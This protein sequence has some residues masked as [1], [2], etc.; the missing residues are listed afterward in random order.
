MTTMTIYPAL[1]VRAGRV[2]RLRQGDFGDETRYPSDP[3]SQARRYRAAG[4]EWL[5][6]VDLDAA[7]NGGYSLQS[8]LADLVQL[9]LRVQTGGGVRSADDVARLLEG[10]ATRVVVGSVAVTDPNQVAGWIDRFGPERLTVAL[11]TRFEAGRWRLPVQGWTTDSG[12]TLQA[13]LA[14]YDRCGLRHLLCTDIDRDGMFAGP[15]LALYR[16]IREQF[17]RFAL[18]ASG[19]VRNLDDLRALQALGVAG[20]VTGKALLEGRLALGEALSC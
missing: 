1:D 9:G 2:V 15:N 7:R 10:G 11:D 4:A 20:V 5:H 19:G 14:D 12:A 13:L 3:P 16:Q 18:Q 8:L 6:L 17:P